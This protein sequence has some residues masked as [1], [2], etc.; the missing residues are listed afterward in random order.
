VANPVW[1]TGLPQ[2]VYTDQGPTYTAQD[3]TVRSSVTSGPAKLRRRFTAVPS[4]VTVSL[5]LSEDEIAIL[6][7]FVK[8]TLGEVLP[9]DWV[10]F[11]TGEAAPYRF[12]AGWSSVKLTWYVGDVW[13]VSMELECL[14]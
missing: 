4:D 14:P 5:Q 3:N 8:D 6:E 1:P 7:T 11:H 13:N 10:K 12:K 2:E 9:F